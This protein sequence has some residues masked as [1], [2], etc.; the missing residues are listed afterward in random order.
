MGP[1]EMLQRLL[2]VAL[3]ETVLFP[4]RPVNVCEHI[5]GLIA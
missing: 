5:P 3:V 4:V 1:L 2:E